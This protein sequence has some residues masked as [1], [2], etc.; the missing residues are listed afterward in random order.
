MHVCC[1]YSKIPRKRSCVPRMLQNQ[2]IRKP[3]SRVNQAV[4]SELSRR[5]DKHLHIIAFCLPPLRCYLQE[6]LLLQDFTSLF[7]VN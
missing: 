5:H 1:I 7:S 4:D 3:T 6:P 2:T